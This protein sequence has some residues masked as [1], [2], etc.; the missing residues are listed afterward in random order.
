MIDLTSH[1]QLCISQHYS[2]SNTYADKD[3]QGQFLSVFF[4]G[5]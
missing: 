3:K 4:S 5:Y 1:P 2:E